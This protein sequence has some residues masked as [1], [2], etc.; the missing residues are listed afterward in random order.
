MPFFSLGGL[1]YLIGMVWLIGLAIRAG[2]TTGDALLW[3]L[4][5][6]F[7]Q[8]LGGICFVIIKREGLVPLA[9]VII[10][11]ILGFWELR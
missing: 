1:V 8:P 6:F 11:I 3:V 10:G 2:E 9:R 4:A 7:C 5:N